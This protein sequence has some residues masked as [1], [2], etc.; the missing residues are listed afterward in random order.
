MYED[1]PTS[2]MPNKL[3]VIELVNENVIPIN[4][5][6]KLKKGSFYCPFFLFTQ[7]SVMM[8][9]LKKNFLI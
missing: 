9:L 6:Q 4:L 7:K 2:N 8:K 5:K 3:R 1:V